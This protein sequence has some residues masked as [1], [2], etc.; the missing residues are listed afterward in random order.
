L[1]INYAVKNSLDIYFLSLIF[2][3]L[4]GGRPPVEIRFVSHELVGMTDWEWTK[5]LQLQST[6]R[7]TGLPAPWINHAAIRWQA[8][9]WHFKGRCAVSLVN[10]P[11][12]MSSTGDDETRLRESRKFS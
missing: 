12:L 4:M 3:P 1:I 7:R 8:T 5:M 9:V 6:L 2:F 10:R 11:P